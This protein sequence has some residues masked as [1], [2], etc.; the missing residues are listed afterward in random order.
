M[1]I[2]RLSS[3]KELCYRQPKP[4]LRKAVLF[5]DI[6]YN[7]RTTRQ[8]TNVSK[9]DKEQRGA[10]DVEAFA[11]LSNTLLEVNEIFDILK[12]GILKDISK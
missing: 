4:T 7:S 8:S 6:N 2:Y 9:N 10:G 11:N 5:G 12:K 3:T 1:E